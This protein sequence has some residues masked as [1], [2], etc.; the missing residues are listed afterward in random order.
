[1]VTEPPRTEPR[2]V[3]SLVVVAAA[4]GA[5]VLALILL[6]RLGVAAQGVNAGFF[7]LGLLGAAALAG[8]ARRNALE[9]G[10]A[11]RGLAL[12]ADTISAPFFLGLSGA[13][14]AWGQDGLAFALGLG[15]GY[16]LLQL[17]IAPLLPRW[18]AVSV[19]DFFA[20]RYGGQ[21]PRLL[22]VVVVVVSMTVLLVAQ[23][24]AAG[25]VAARLLELDLGAGI[26]IAAGAL[27]ICYLLKG[28]AGSP[29]VAGLL[30]P[31]MLVAF[32]APAVQLSVQRYGLPVPQIAYANALWQVQGLEETLLEQDL[33]DPALM[34]PMLGPFL[35]LTSVN[36]LGLILGLAAGMACLPHVLAR[37]CSGPS[38]REARWSAVW[39]LAFAA[40]LLTA[41]PALAAYARLALLSLI[42]D[43]TELSALP[44]WMF[45][46]GKL[47]LVEICGHP[48]TSAAAVAGACAALPDAS[49][50]LRLQ[51]LT[52]RPDMI[53]LATPE[54]AGLDPATLGVLAA[55]ALAAALVTAD[56]P[57]ATIVGA[58]GRD[59]RA[60][61]GAPPP[62][63]SSASFAIAAVAVLVADLAAVT[64]PAGLL[65]L[66]TWAFTL[67]A[68]GL[69]P[70]LL[71]GL[72]WRRANAYGAGAAMAAG[73]A[74]CLLY[75][76]GTR[77][78]AVG[79]FETWQSL[80]SAGM[81]ARETF[82]DLKQAWM[83]SAPGP[84]KDA[85]W[86]ALDAH[87]QTIANWWG[88]K[89]LATALLALP[90]GIVAVIAVSLLTP[91]PRGEA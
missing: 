36:V 90:V 91:A 10:P 58:I 55:A 27:L 15:A 34:K 16:L 76:V 69:L 26:A 2:L 38:A 28:G 89:A 88:V 39:A 46:Y 23:L 32:L 40:L 86:A 20:K 51:D 6:P 63:G 37:H 18:G 66:A 9:A 81:T 59:A 30:F 35:S 68:A 24:T 62:P 1:M 74:V 80:S 29:W 45:A 53:A 41:A 22:A 4:A 77:Y 67:A 54:I 79:F 7:L 25:L 82:A 87:A 8:L 84:A 17:L 73:F 42:G 19:P 70:A 49:T 50:V 44:G 71:A 57:L 11:L 5:G 13:V 83:I 12:A 78:F 52:L 85:A 31:L 64:R 56:G 47:G 65:T 60:G 72:W 3:H 48:A 33:A 14:F 21:I 61:H 75:L 43:H